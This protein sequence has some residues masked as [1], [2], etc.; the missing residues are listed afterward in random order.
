MRNFFGKKNSLGSSSSEDMTSP[1]DP[2]GFSPRKP[3]LSRADSLPTF[4]TKKHIP[5]KKSA[6]QKLAEDHQSNSKHQDNQSSSKRSEK[7]GDDDEPEKPVRRNSGILTSKQM[8]TI[9]ERIQKSVDINIK[10]AYIEAYDVNRFFLESYI[11]ECI[12]EFKIAA[13]CVRISDVAS[14]NKI[15]VS[16]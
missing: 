8:N 16:W 14:G 2:F 15:L 6:D 7:K 12:I 11:R 5:L 13:G 9:R 4:E 3:D 1:R 10:M